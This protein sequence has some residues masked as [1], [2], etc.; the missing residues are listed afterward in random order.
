MPNVGLNPKKIHQQSEGVTYTTAIITI[1]M[2]LPSRMFSMKDRITKLR[3]AA[4]PW[5][6]P[7]LLVLSYKGPEDAV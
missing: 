6:G 3:K 5:D 2:V 1:K 7:S 4:E